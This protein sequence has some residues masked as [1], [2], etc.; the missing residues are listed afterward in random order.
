M[1]RMRSKRGTLRAL[2]ARAAAL[3]TIVLSC[4]TVF[5]ETPSSVGH[6]PNTLILCIDTLRADALGPY[7][8]G[9]MP[10]LDRFADNAVVFQQAASV[11]SWTKPSVPSILTGLYPF[12]H[13]VL[14]S[15]SDSVD[16]LDGSVK[17]VAETVRDSGWRTA[18][19]VNNE[20]LERRYSG[21]ERGFERYV[22]RAGT[23]P[24]IVARFF[25]WLEAPDERPFFAYLHF[26]D[27]HQP[28]NPPDFIPGREPG[29]AERARIGWSAMYGW[30]WWLA[31]EAARWQRVL[32]DTKM[33]DTLRG[34][35]AAEVYA[36][37]S[38][39]GG[40]MERLN[41]RGLLDRTLVIVTSDHGEG[42]LEH[43]KLDH[44]YGPYA[45]LIEI[46]MIVRAPG[47]A[48]TTGNVAAP[49]QLTD[50]APTVYDAL[51]LPADARLPGVSML[52]I[53]EEP[54]K[55]QDRDVV[56]Q[57]QHGRTINLSLRRGGLVY[58]RSDLA[59]PADDRR[60]GRMPT[61]LE[62]GVRLQIEGLFNG[63][64][65]YA[66]DVER[67]P[68]GDTDRELSGPLE[69]WDGSSGRILGI[70]FTLTKTAD[71][72]DEGGEEAPRAAI[73]AGDW[74]RVDFVDGDDTH[75]DR[76]QHLLQ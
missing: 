29:V 39:V 28:Y 15:R 62:S 47:A 38:V 44:G 5:A 24:E 69:S 2:A 17:T 40:L 35:Y 66:A 68:A 46:P 41:A 73:A 63:S 19:F 4:T 9:P 30:H 8:G 21:L 57:E 10:H 11:A 16:V 7:G 33:V 26:L 37:D 51:K 55:W 31:R 60:P 54:A 32:L 49:V 22:E 34:L 65:V 53:A 75:V 1:T 3:C 72:T 27:P 36:V 71:V 20:H 12:Q 59:R 67:L 52:D 43:G 23:P 50:I 6:R 25:A 64:L 13:G 45:E 70:D 74:I 14:E 76:L 48:R 42:F 56:T 18:A 58:H 61:R